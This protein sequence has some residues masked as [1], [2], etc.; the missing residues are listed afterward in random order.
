MFSV[1][2]RRRVRV[3]RRRRRNDFCFS[4]QNRLSY[5]LDIWDTESI[6]LGKCS[7]WPLVILTEGHDCD[8]DKQKFACLQDKVRTTQ[9]ITTKIC[10]YIPLVMVITWLDFGWIA[11]GNLFFAKFKKNQMCFFKVKRFIGHISIIH[12]H[13]CDL[14]VTM[15]GWVDVP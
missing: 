6:G 10:T 9:P 5:T 11:V 15:V 13:N 14:W 8:I 1:R 7:V 4:R 3:R 2:F 12:D